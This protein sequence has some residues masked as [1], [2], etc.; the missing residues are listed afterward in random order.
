MDIVTSIQ[1]DLLTLALAGRLGADT[2]SGFDQSWITPGIRRLTVDLG[3]CS[4]VSS[5]GLRVFIKLAREASNKSVEFSLV[6][7]H[8][9]V[10]QVL[11]MT[12]LT[13]L[14][15]IRRKAREI[16]IDGLDFL[17]AGVCGQCFR[18]DSET[19]VK[20][21][22]EGVAPEVAEQEKTFARAALIAGI[23]TALSYDVVACG[24]RTGVIYEMLDAQLFSRVIAAEPAAA[25]RYGEQ[26]ADIARNIH[27]KVGDV[28]VFPD[29]KPRMRSYIGNLRGSL[30]DADIE[31]LLA[32]LECIPDA[33]TLVHFDL[34]TSN[35]MIR[36]GEPVIIDM[37]DVSRGHYLFDVG[38]I[39]TIYAYPDSGNCEF[40]TKVPNAIGRQLYESFVRAYFSDRP[41]EELDFFNR[42][43]AFLAS[44]RLIAAIAFLPAAKETLLEKVRDFLMPRIYAESVQH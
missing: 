5:A 42:N 15:Q 36:E 11:E 34:H 28:T 30:S 38:V 43:E 6:K 1:G 20:L 18:L 25:S 4:F 37:G 17:S 44:L 29:L 22:N 3:A 21:Y 10:Y 12:G 14:M 9:S 32:R 24:E 19:V 8:P 27:T 33:D 40:V 26:L 16:S 41:A 13:Q 35:I 39:A 23:P 31:H 2:V 7:V